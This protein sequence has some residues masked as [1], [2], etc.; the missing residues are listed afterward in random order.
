[1]AFWRPAETALASS[2]EATALG[3]AAWAT[4]ARTTALG[5]GAFAFADDSV[6]LGS[7]S[8]ADRA[9]TVSVGSFGNERQIVNVAAGTEQTDAV[10]LAQL[11][12]KYVQATAYTDTAVAL[13]GTAANA[14]TDNRETHIR[15]DMAAGD[16]ATLS[17]ANAYTD[18]RLAEFSAFDS[19]VDTLENQVGVLDDRVNRIGALSAAMS[20]MSAAGA[21]NQNASRLSLGVGNYGGKTAFAVGYQRSLSKRTTLSFG[22]AHDGKKAATGGGVSVGW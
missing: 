19:R 20:Q 15:N 14:Y 16:A 11:E 2:G 4:G 7:R 9:N 13:G 1:M 10:N 12:A 21:G 3:A 22:A 8:Q 5:S 17:A 18:D 6:A